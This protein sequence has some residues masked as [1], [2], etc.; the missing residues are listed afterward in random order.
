M[1]NHH[2]QRVVVVIIERANIET[3]LSSEE[4]SSSGKLPKHRQ[5]TKTINTLNCQT[6]ELYSRRHRRIAVI[7]KSRRQSQSALEQNSTTIDP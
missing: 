1:P 5:A 6:V 4:P 7:V 2:H 3:V